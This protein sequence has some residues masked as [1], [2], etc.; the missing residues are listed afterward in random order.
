MGQLIG[1]VGIYVLTVWGRGLPARLGDGGAAAEIAA[2]ELIA[3][4]GVLV[5][6]AGAVCAWQGRRNRNLQRLLLDMDH[7]RER[8]AAEVR[9]EA[10]IAELESKNAEL[11]QF[12]YAVS[13]DLK[14]PLI[15]IRGF[16]GILERDLVERDPDKIDYDLGKIRHAADHMRQ[17]LEDLLTLSRADRRTD[18]PSPVPLVRL[19]AEAVELVAG[20]LVEGGVAVEISPDLPTVLGDRTR[21]RVVFQNLLDNAAKFALDN[22]SPEIR[23]GARRDGGEDVVFVAD[24]GIGLSPEHCERIFQPFEQVDSAKG[25]TG[26]GL[27]IVQRVI[28]AHGGRLW[29]ESDGL[30]QGCRFC[31]VLPSATGPDPA[32]TELADVVA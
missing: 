12:T 16:L 30:H 22:A 11:E 14:S 17:L 15:T 27:A 19:A 5:V 28:Q 3:L 24:N 4:S 13:H 32:D 25:G 21:L 29:V 9:Q 26:L 2:W 6:V 10:L 1:M 23:I 7:V 20:R 18:E 8:D 31:F